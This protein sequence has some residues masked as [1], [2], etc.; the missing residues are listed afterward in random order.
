MGHENV[1]GAGAG[2]RARR[3]RGRCSFVTSAPFCC[4]KRYYLGHEYDSEVGGHAAAGRV[5]PR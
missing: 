1:G 4:L 5:L 2:A 3:E